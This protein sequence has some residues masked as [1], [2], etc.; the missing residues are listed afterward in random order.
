M[1]SVFICKYHGHEVWIEKS[2]PRIIGVLHRLP[3]DVMEG[4]SCPYLIHMIYFSFA[5]F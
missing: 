1:F 2:I 5:S 4:F 3:S